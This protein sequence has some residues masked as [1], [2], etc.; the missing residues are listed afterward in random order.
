[1]HWQYQAWPRLADDVEVGVEVA[2]DPV[3]LPP[4][5]AWVRSCVGG[6]V[7]SLATEDETVDGRRFRHFSGKARVALID[8]RT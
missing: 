1:M 2:H 6:W 4:R 5:R 7:E 3:V 8:Q